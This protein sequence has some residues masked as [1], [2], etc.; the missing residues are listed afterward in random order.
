MSHPAVPEPLC[1][2]KLPVD[3]CPWCA[4]ARVVQEAPPHI[5]ADLGAEQFHQAIGPIDTDDPHA[6]V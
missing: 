4:P 5:L 1:P 2:H 6:H 3:D